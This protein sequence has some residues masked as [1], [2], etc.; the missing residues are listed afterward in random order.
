M[1]AP[2]FRPFATC[3]KLCET[4]SLV[5]LR[6]Y[7]SKT[8]SR[9]RKTCRMEVSTSSSCRAPCACIRRAPDRPAGLRAQHSEGGP[10]HRRLRRVDRLAQRA[11][12]TRRER[13]WRREHRGRPD[14]EVL[15]RLPR[16]SSGIGIFTRLGSKDLCAFSRLG[17]DGLPGTPQLATVRTS[18]NGR[19]PTS[20][21]FGAQAGFCEQGR[22]VA[23][24]RTRA[25]ERGLQS[26][27][28]S[29]SLPVGPL[30]ADDL[31]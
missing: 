22:P 14:G 27:G 21:Q 5:Q 9:L 1:R 11:Q 10:R 30:R 28:R 19:K 25:P 29:I 2:P 4:N 6:N 7:K 20:T 12:P 24:M 26:V 18:A 31:V 3:A 8:T 13:R 17:S 15:F 16:Q 23:R